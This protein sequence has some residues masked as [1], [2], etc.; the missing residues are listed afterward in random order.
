MLEFSP[1]DR[2]GLYR[3]AVAGDTF[4]TAVYLA[5]AGHRVHYLTRLGD[6]PQSAQIRQCMAAEGIA[7]DRVSTCPGRRPG[8]YL[9]ENDTAGERH[10]SYWRD[11]SPAREIFDQPLQLADTDVFYFSGI[12]LAVTRSGV[13]NL[14]A[15]L[16][17]IRDSGG[18]VVFDPNYRPTLWDNPGQARQ[19]I[20]A[21]LP[22][23]DI[24]LPTLQ[25]ERTLWGIETVAECRALFATEGVTELVI[26]GDD[27]TAYVFSSEGEVSQQAPAVAALDTT[28][29]GDA[30][31]AAYLG[32]RLDGLDLHTAL[33]RAQALAARVVQQRGAILPRD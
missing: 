1:E 6:D 30:F 20:K 21:V 2:D 5:R 28:G 15:L 23:C 27:L 24:A 13:E 9:I 11:H 22:L 4:N 8:L 31:N 14:L 33:D 10:F 7:T 3:R 29:A 25:D 32:A 12:T 26:K 18:R 17:Q 16:R 19:T